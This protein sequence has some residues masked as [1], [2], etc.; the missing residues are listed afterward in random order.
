MDVGRF[1]DRIEETL[2]EEQLHAKI[3]RTYLGLELRITFDGLLNK[4]GAQL[5]NQEGIIIDV[6]QKTLE[7]YWE[8][9]S[10]IHKYIRTYGTNPIMEEIKEKWKD[11]PSIN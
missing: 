5:V 3:N 8:L 6:H 11:S 7:R 1:D 4:S 10:L 9:C 2:T